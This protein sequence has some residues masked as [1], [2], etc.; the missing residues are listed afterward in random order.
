MRSDWWF[1]SFGGEELVGLGAVAWTNSRRISAVRKLVRGVCQSVV[2]NVSRKH[3][4]AAGWPRTR[5]SGA[6]HSPNGGFARWKRSPRPFWAS[7]GSRPGPS[8]NGM[9]CTA[10]G[11]GEEVEARHWVP[12]PSQDMEPNETTEG[13]PEQKALVCQQDERV[14]NNENTRSLWRR[15][16]HTQ[17]VQQARCKRGCKSG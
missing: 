17:T 9:R 6:R 8:R 15:N 16:V 5:P 13:S 11:D 10:F 1:R 7:I 2:P 3:G 12:A 4:P 14:C